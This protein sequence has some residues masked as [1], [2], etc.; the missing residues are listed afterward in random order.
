MTRLT[1]FNLV[2]IEFDPILANGSG[3]GS[4]VFWGSI[5]IAV[6][7]IGGV[8]VFQLRK[9]LLDEDDATGSDDPFGLQ[10]LRDL[11]KSGQISE[12]EYQKLRSALIA[13]LK[14][15]MEEPSEAEPDFKTA[16]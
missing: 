11:R 15:T 3:A 14:S 4:V 9:K 2:G 7:L 5:I 13:Q 16:E 8:I 1:I 12:Q 10:E 6:I